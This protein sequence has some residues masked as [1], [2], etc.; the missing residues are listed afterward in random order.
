MTH[1]DHERARILS[2]AMEGAAENMA[3]QDCA[4]FYEAENHKALAATRLAVIYFQSGEFFYS[5]SDEA[6]HALIQ[7]CADYI[8]RRVMETGE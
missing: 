8:R 7:E 3:I 6:F 5:P 4:D 1:E 2:R